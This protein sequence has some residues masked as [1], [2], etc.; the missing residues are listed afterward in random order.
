MVNGVGKGDFPVYTRGILAD[1]AV[2]LWPIGFLPFRLTAEPWYLRFLPASFCLQP[3]YT[4][5]L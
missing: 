1:R 4:Q 2:L 3:H 5:F